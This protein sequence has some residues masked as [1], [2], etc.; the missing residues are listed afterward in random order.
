LRFV[1]VREGPQRTFDDRY[2]TIDEAAAA[3]PR[4]NAAE[5]TQGFKV[6]PNAAPRIDPVQK[7]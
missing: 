1:L 4:Q 3:A 7:A 5:I 6:A 2:S